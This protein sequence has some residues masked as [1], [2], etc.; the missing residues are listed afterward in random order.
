MENLVSAQFLLG[1][2]A[3]VVIGG[4]FL[5]AAAV[6][7]LREALWRLLARRADGVIAG[8]RARS[9]IYYTVY[10]YVTAEG[11]ACRATDRTGSSLSGGRETGRAVRLLYFP[12][13]PLYIRNA[14]SCAAVVVALLCLAAGLAF[15]H[16]AGDFRQ[17]GWPLAGAALLVAA[18]LVWRHTR[19]PSAAQRARMS[20]DHAA[21][22]KR[23][24]P[25][26]PIETILDQTPPANWTPV[27]A[28]LPHAMYIGAAA[29]AGY[30]VM[31][32]TA[33][34][35]TAKAALQLAAAVLVAWLAR[36]AHKDRR[37]WEKFFGGKS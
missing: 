11:I 23:L 21:R 22:D 2:A 35:D 29:L 16:A 27:P 7:L 4:L 19:P 33:T 20:E 30:A 10:D 14:G 32:Q 13:D 1:T 28:F 15:L 8:V 3:Y 37:K 5:L 34:G 6:L 25:V 26:L 24:G 31:T 18:G 12:H 36:L 17:H 9:R